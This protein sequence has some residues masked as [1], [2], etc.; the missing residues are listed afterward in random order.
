MLIHG[1]DGRG[2]SLF[3]VSVIADLYDQGSGI[4]FLCGYH[5]ARD[6]FDLQTNSKHDAVIIEEGFD[7]V[8]VQKKR[9][10]FVPT[11]RSDL[12]GTVIET[13][14]DANERVVFFK[15]F[16]LFETSVFKNI[17]NLSSIVLMG[18][19]DKCAF[20]SDVLGKDWAS[21]V[22]FSVPQT[23]VG[24]KIRS[25]DKYKGYFFSADKEGVVSVE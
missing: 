16:D 7:P 13:V 23:D 18:N 8:E 21:Q 15:N 1:D 24:A 12:L 25:V 11:E 10:I 19:I 14:A 9:V 17:E 4:I 22:Y 3:S 20:R 2:A 5:M 6:E